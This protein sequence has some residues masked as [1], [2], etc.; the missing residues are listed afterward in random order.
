MTTACS[1]N[2]LQCYF[3]YAANDTTRVRICKEES[4]TPHA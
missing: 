2:V 3:L 1:S 4:E